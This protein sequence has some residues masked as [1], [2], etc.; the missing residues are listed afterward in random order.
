MCTDDAFSTNRIF[1]QVNGCSYG[2]R[3]ILGGKNKYRFKTKIELSVCAL[4]NR[5]RI[6]EDLSVKLRKTRDSIH[7][8]THNERINIEHFFFFFME[9]LKLDG[10]NQRQQLGEK[11]TKNIYSSSRPSGWITSL[12]PTK[13]VKWWFANKLVSKVRGIN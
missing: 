4:V 12:E 8:Y 9:A 2:L 3:S 11:K 5:V 7:I 13:I 1:I 6:D 10:T